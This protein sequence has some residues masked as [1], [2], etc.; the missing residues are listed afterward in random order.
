MTIS[1]TRKFF[2]NASPEP[3]LQRKLKLAFGLGRAQPAIDPATMMRLDAQPFRDQT[4]I[5]GHLELFAQRATVELAQ[6]DFIS[7]PIPAGDVLSW[8]EGFEPVSIS[9]RGG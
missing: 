5:F 4:D 9:D 3:Q 6:S 8:L 1:H 2:I 7:K